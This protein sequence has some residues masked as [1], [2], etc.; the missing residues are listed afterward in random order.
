MSLQ[1]SLF[2]LLRDMSVDVAEE[3]IKVRRVGI[4]KMKMWLNHE[5]SSAYMASFGAQ[6]QLEP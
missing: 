3:K 6:S 2:L 4:K 1:L 5:V